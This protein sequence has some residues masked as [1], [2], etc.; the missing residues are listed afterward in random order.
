MRFCTECD[1]MLVPKEYNKGTTSVLRYE[2][3]VCSRNQMALEGNAN[4]NCVYRTDFTA[5]EEDLSVDK[6]CIKDPTLTRR[7]DVE[8]KHCGNNEAVAYTQVTK[9]KLIL[10]FVCCKCAGHWTSGKGARDEDEEFSED[11]A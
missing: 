10:V 4:E 9:D 5:R 1:N 8:C 11:T 7:R 3:K 6:E 2:C